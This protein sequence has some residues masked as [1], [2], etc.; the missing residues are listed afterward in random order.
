MCGIAGVVG[1]RGGDAEARVRAA[2]ARLGH[3]G[4]DGEGLHVGEG[5]V[6]GMRRLAIIDLAHGEQPIRD[7]RGGLACVCNGEI[8]D[9][10]EHFAALRA[11]GHRLQS[12]SDVNVIPHTYEE[13]GADAV[14]E[15]RGMF[16]AALWD[17]PRRQLVLWRDRLGK[18]P[19]FYAQRDGALL[20]ASELPALVAMLGETPPIDPAAVREY[21]R[22]GAV[23][24]PMTI[25]RDVWALPPACHLT[26]RAGEA[27]RVTRYW[28]RHEVPAFAG[29]R[30]EALAALDAALRE[31][32]AIRLRSDVPVGLFLSGGIDSGL[33]ASYAAEAGARDLLCFAVQVGDAALD[34]SALARA[35]AA[36]LGLPVETIPLTI[37]PAADVER[38]VAAYGQPF[39]DSSAIPT[40]LVAAA[41]SRRRKVVLT[42]DGGDEVFAGYRRYLLPGLWRGAP[43][44]GVPMLGAAGRALARIGGR[45]SA[46]GFAARALRGWG[47]PEAER[48]L[49]WTSDLLDA[50]TLARVAPGLGDAGSPRVP[51]GGVGPVDRRCASLRDFL[52]T[53]TRLILADVLLT[54][55]DIATMSRSVEARSP[56][57]DAALLELSWSFPEAWLQSGRATKPL[58]RALAARRLPA[59]VASA[60]KRGFEV[61]LARWL[62]HELRP[63]VGDTLLAPDAR[64]SSWC[65]PRALRAFVEGRD[66]FAGNR[67]QSV[68]A[69]LMLELFLRRGTG[70]G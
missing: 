5:V 58:L 28:D 55:M 36:R 9:H 60:P 67:A 1:W 24:H 47:L 51:P 66:A 48:Y 21:L 13:R 17:A 42:G 31:A 8:Y 7:E 52:W 14:R 25:Y 63:L 11:R 56:L 39:A 22:V 23:P 57:L 3:R 19:L 15:W 70:G 6:L 45:R 62:R 37:D 59:E 26:F 53:D 12:A 64:V 30:E 16:A 20:F 44:R 46:G 68:W 38:I 40:T 50:P 43:P 18:K 35:T 69:L 4:P 49:A 27:P 10:P 33:V 2:L 41:A 61:P 32:V 34:E 29:T 65:E 54:K